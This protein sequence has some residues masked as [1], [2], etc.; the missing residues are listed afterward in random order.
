VRQELTRQGAAPLGPAE[1]VLGFDPSGV[2]KSGTAAVGV[3]RPWCGR[4]G[5]VDPG[6]GAV[7][8]GSGAGAGH[9]LVALR[10]SLPQAWTTAKA[11]LAPAGVPTARRG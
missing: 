2:P 6:P 11:R 8:L 5:T 10:L 9:T 1:G 7:S 4:R 3:A